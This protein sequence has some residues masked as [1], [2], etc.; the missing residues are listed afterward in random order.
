M[1]ILAGLTV[2][3][4]LNAGAVAPCDAWKMDLEGCYVHDTETVLV[5]TGPTF[6]TKEFI[7]YHEIGHHLFDRKINSSKARKLFKSYGEDETLYEYFNVS[8]Y[9]KSESRGELVADEF[10][11]WLL[12]IK[13]KDTSY[14]PTAKRIQ[15][16]KKYCNEKCVKDIIS[17]EIPKNNG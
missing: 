8:N 7:L 11:L 9:R 2:L 6:Y 17:I 5:T 12:S 3:F 13:Y 16:F 4:V 10:A 1:H 15:Y 14:Q